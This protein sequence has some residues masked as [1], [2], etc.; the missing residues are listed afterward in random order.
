MSNQEYWDRR[1]T[2]EG[3]IWGNQPSV[4]ARYAA[5]LFRQAGVKSLLVPGSGYGRHTRFFAESGFTVTG[6]EISSV[7]LELARRFDPF[8][9][10]YSGSVLELSFCP[11][12][13]DALFCFNVLHLFLAD[14]RK[15]MIHECASHIVVGGCLFFTV[16]SEKETDFGKGRKVEPHTFESRPG[17]PTHYFTED[18]LR[19]YFT[20]YHVI[21]SGLME[22]PE[23]HGGQPHTHVLRYI[24]VSLK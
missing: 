18:D 22:D 12:R 7:A 5:G 8:S 11:D 9:R 20:Q 16:C 19:S 6:I 17:R 15:T 4:A 3:R 24:F 14:D 13:Y 1:Y 2:A 10:F 21:E 23:D